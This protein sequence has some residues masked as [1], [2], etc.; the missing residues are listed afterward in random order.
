MASAPAAPESPLRSEH[1]VIA[2][3]VDLS[4]RHCTDKLL[5]Q[6]SVLECAGGTILQLD[7]ASGH[8]LGGQKI[9]RVFR[10]AGA[11]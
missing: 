4:S 7:H 1:V 11:A 6:K 8:A 3:H 5:Y 9:T 2:G 10:H